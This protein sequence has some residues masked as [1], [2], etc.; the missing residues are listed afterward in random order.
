MADLCKFYKKQKYVSYDN[1]QTWQ[2]LEIY[3]R[4][5]LYETNSPSCGSG[6]FQYRW[7]LVDGAYICDG[8]D[9][10]T[11]LIYQYSQDG[12]YWYN[13]FPTM[14]TK[15]ALVERDSEFCNNAGGGGYTSG[16]TEPISGDTPTCPSGYIWDPN[17]EDC[18][19]NGPTDASGNCQPCPE[20]Y[21]YNT[22]TFE[23]ECQG[24]F[25]ND[26]N[27]VVCGKYEEWDD[28]I[29][30]C[31]CETK[32]D[33]NGNCIRCQRNSSWD[34]SREECVCNKSFEMRNGVCVYVD[35]LKTVKCDESKSAITSADTSYYESG[36]TLLNYT[37]GDCIIR[38]GDGAFNGHTILTSVTIS[39]SVTEVGSFAFANCQSLTTLSFPSNLRQLESGAFSNCI[40]LENVYFDGTLPSTIPSYLFGGCY[41]LQSASWLL[42][43]NISEIGDFAFRNCYSLSNVQL[44]NTLTSIGNGSFFN[45]DSINSITIPSSTTVVG[46]VGFKNSSNLSSVVINSSAITIGDEAFA[47]CASLTAVTVNSSAVTIGDRV[48]DNC[49]RLLKLKFTSPTPFAISEGFFDNT[50]ECMIF[51]P[52]GSLEAYK[53]AWSAYEDRI[54][55]N[56]TGVYY[57]WVD[58]SGVFCD[59]SD[60]YTRQK[61]QSTL[62]GITW[63]DTGVY[64][65]KDFITHYSPTCGYQGEVALTVVNEDGYTRYYEPCE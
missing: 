17:I 27:C 23:C 3:E 20:N 56:D 41:S 9:R 46:S 11:K 32:I 45:C 43:N 60:E 37:I 63:T 28:N 30:E 33:E 34:D 40:G 19:C 64:R 7:Q 38:I 25:D 47:N 2:S 31:V 44:P 26:G 18:V 6:V 15:G 61:Q 48:F 52:C 58:D 42:Y 8:K 21:L 24:H 62:N 39:S 14:Y 10:Y 49:D 12:V 65:P 53:A 54:Y 22:T 55:C 13:Y 4:G 35:P 1:G 50:N 59:G 51:V 29:K 5:E 57:R 16:D 36:W